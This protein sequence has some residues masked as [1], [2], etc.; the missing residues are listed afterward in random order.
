MTILTILGTRPEFIKSAPVSEAIGQRFEELVVH[1]GQHYDFAMAELFI[2]EL[3]LRIPDI[4]LELSKGNPSRQVAQI[5]EGIGAICRERRPDIVLIYGDTNSTL[6][7][8]V[9]GSVAG[10]RVV[11][12]EAGLRS[13]DMS[14]PEERNRLVADRL[15]SVHFCSSSEGLAN[16]A[17]EGIQGP[18]VRVVGDVNLDA[19]LAFRKRAAWPERV[20]TPAGPFCFLTLHREG[21]VDDR[22]RMGSILE[23]V[24]RWG[25]TVIWPLH[26]RVGK[27]L[28]EHGVDLP[29]NVLTTEPLSF[30]ETIA[31]AEAA[32]VI[33]TDSGGLQKEAYWLGTPCV[34]TRPSTEW[35]ETIEEGWN[36]LVDADPTRILEGLS[37][38]PRADARPPLYGDGTA[39]AQITEI[40]ESFL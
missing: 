1:T 3:D 23:G 8:A 34:T 12:V 33:L 38:P 21:N 15:A 9:A 28:V 25:G 31:V 14:M 36:V 29:P 16:L 40:L 7:A 39:A 18:W 13:F 32:T 5:I 26:P 2:K 30:T 19:L 37:S 11:H 27:A 22:K 17:R 24:T 6:A 20:R 10:V 35:V 4:Q